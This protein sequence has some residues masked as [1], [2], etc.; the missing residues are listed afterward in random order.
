[1]MS[2]NR[3][4]NTLEVIMKA[5]DQRLPMMDD[6]HHGALRLF[7]GFYE[8]CP[9]LVIDLYGR[10]LLIFNYAEDPGERSAF[11]ASIQAA[12]GERLPWLEAGIL[13]VRNSP[14]ESE[15][16]G[17]LLFGEAADDW[18]SEGG[19]RYALNLFLHQDAGLYLDTRGLRTWIR[20][21]AS[22]KRVLNTFAYTGSLGAAAL[23]G[24]AVQV[25]QTDL[26]RRFLEV[27]ER[28]YA[29][30]G[31]HAR[32][33][34]LVAGDFFRVTGRM[35]K[36]QALFDIV[37]IDPPFFSQT[38]AGRI[39]QLENSLQLIN[40]VR[41]LVAHDGWLVMVNNALY[42]SGEEY[43][44]Q[45]ESLTKGGYIRIEE[46]IPVPQDVTGYPETI[47]R[48]PPAD[49]APFNHSTKIAVLRVTR[50]DERA[51]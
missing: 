11:I 24:G 44:K 13:K 41:P 49:P 25:I 34:D 27:A 9:E 33:A 2:N 8:G 32:S 30:N 50:K 20:E 15:R 6:D 4:M 28:T 16:R 14:D 43:M 7:N 45:L 1:M 17:I 23:V 46:I 3:D 37:I 31:L 21:N 26:N 38:D 19:V 35:R 5:V 29:L 40:K 22:G 47:Q 39:D 12:L 48:Q 10:C 18:V 36:Q 51:V 42:L